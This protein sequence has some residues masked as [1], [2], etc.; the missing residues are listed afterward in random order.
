MR[1]EAGAGLDPI[2]VP[3]A[4]RAPA[5][6]GRVMIVGEAEVVA[7]VQPAVVGVAERSERADVD[8]DGEMGPY[9]D[10][11][12]VSAMYPQVAGIGGGF[13]GIMR[14]RHLQQRHL[15][16]GQRSYRPRRRSDDQAPASNNFPSV[17]NAPARQCIA[18]RSPR[19]LGFA[20]PY[21]PRL[22]LDVQPWGIAWC[23]TVTRG[24]SSNGAPGSE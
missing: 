17:T 16:G 20:H 8:H 21:R 10:A 24:R 23:P 22:I 2:V 14:R 3:D 9:P 4:D 12:Q 18:R 11:N 15:L 13:F 7:G 5:H 19:H 6:P 1:R